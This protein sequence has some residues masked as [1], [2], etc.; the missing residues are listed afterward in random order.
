MSTSVANLGAVA[1]A[2]LH[3]PSR[4]EPKVVHPS[5]AVHSR[6]QRRVTHCPQGS[7]RH[8]VVMDTEPPFLTVKEVAERLRA[9]PSW[10]REQA[11]SGGLP[12]YQ[13]GERWRFD[14]IDLANWLDT[15][16]SWAPAK[17]FRRQ[18][19]ERRR[20][21][22]VDL[23]PPENL[24]LASMVTAAEFASEFVIT[25]DAVVRW[26]KDGLVPGYHAGRSW[27]IDRGV[28]EE[29]RE[30]LAAFPPVAEFPVGAA[31]STSIRY[32]IAQAMLG[33]RGISFTAITYERRFGDPIQWVP[34]PGSRA[35]R[36]RV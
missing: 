34:K 31:R 2:E 14:P 21:S 10:V 18:Y 29:C 33:R 9:S 11:E 19:P 27:L 28:L 22:G 20:T 36:R 17:A 5:L 6:L 26:M 25:R 12:A 24:D 8:H 15:R 7:S 1:L 32:T 3:Q 16:R 30:I 35:G 13:V 23:T 4:L